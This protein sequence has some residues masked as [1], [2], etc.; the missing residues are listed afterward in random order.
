MFNRP[1][2]AAGNSILVTYFSATGTTKAV[3][4]AMARTFGA[5]LYAIT[6][7]KAYTNADLDWHDK[8]SRSSIEMADGKSRPKL[9]G[10]L[11]DMGK[12]GTVFIGYPIWWGIAPR[13]VQTF[14]EQCDFKGKKVIPFCTS[15]SSP[16]AGSAD[17][18]SAAASGAEWLPGKRLDSRAGS[19]E[20]A[21]WAKELGV[22]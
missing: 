4:E 5:D 9:A 13:I 20:L 7:E 16:F 22:K 18:L 21:A 19:E 14:V 12:Y 8:T 10:P 1:A 3:A 11:P 17:L 2:L 15:G 6:P